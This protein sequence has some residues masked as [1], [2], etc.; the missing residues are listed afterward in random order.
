MNPTPSPPSPLSRDDRFLAGRRAALVGFITNLILTIGKIAAGLLGHS[1]AMLADGLESLSDMVADGILLLAMRIARRGADADHPYG[2]GKFETLAT[3]ATSLLILAMAGTIVTMAFGKFQE[4]S[5]L[6]PTGIALVAAVVTILTKEALFRYT[7][8]IGRRINAKAVIANAWHHRSD[9]ISTVASLI[10]IVL[11]MYG[12]PLADP[13]A[14]IIVAFI[15]GRLGIQ[16]LGEAIRDLTDAA[17]A[18]DQEI[19]EKIASLVKTTPNVRSVHLL[20][21]RRLGPDILVDV[22]VVVHPHL[23]VSEG[24]QIAEKVRLA[25]EDG[26]RGLIDVMVHVDTEDDQL[27][28]AVPIFPDRHSLQERL[29]PCLD[30]LAALSPPLRVVSHYAT[31]GIRLELGI[32]ASSSVSLAVA[33]REAATLATRIVQEN[34]DIRQVWIN[35]PLAEAGVADDNATGVAP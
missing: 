22:H 14:A 15:L 33:Q 1:T 11:G 3:L 4:P 32:G 29:E 30:G 17:S 21:A 31:S 27:T 25:L 28:G 9:A 6:P 18:I 23:S 10:G 16:F 19:Q 24:H 12:W 26:I 8:A 35:T 34:P 7:I 2:H 20:K 13:I 5:L